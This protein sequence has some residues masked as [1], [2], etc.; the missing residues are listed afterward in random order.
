MIQCGV[1]VKPACLKVIWGPRCQCFF[2]SLPSHWIQCGGIGDNL[3]LCLLRGWQ[4]D[5][6]VPFGSAWD[7]SR[8]F[9]LWLFLLWHVQGLVAWPFVWHLSG[10]LELVNVT[11]II[12]IIMFIYSHMFTD[13][14]HNMHNIEISKVNIYC[15]NEYRMRVGSS[16]TITVVCLDVR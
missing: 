13:S 1:G 3:R 4:P 7:E 12:I 15:I 16:K 2:G 5:F 11:S 10:H 8:H 6:S 9:P 14:H